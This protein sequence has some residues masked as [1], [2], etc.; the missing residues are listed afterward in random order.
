MDVTLRV[1]GK[2]EKVEVDDGT[3]LID[4]LRDRLGLVG[5]KEGCGAGE[6][7]ACTVLLDGRPVCACTTP[8][9]QARDRS[10]TTIEG[11]DD[12]RLAETIRAAFI[13]ADAVQCGFCTPGQILT[14]Y[15]L[16]KD[17]PRPTRAEIRSALAGNACRCTGYTAIVNAVERAAERLSQG[18]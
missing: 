18:G 14:A 12:D 3:R 16:L 2:I 15:S 11:L 8:A 5:T 17:T 1:N 10:V 13:E 7:G 9:F 4:L 6:C